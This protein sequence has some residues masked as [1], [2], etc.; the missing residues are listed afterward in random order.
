MA[1]RLAS[2]P[3]WSARPAVF[4]YDLTELAGLDC[5]SAASG[6]IAEAQALAAGLFGARQS[7]FLVNG[8]TAGVQAAILATCGE[9]DTLVIARNSHLSAVTGMA[10][11]GCRPRWVCPAVDEARGV[12]HGVA[13]E[14]IA[15][16]LDAASAAGERVGA[17]LVTSPTYFG[18]CSDVAALAEACHA[19]GVPLL[20]D[21]A[22]GSHLSFLPDASSPLSAV[23]LGADAV[24]QST[25]KTLGSL[26]QSAMLHLGGGAGPPRV[27]AARVESALQALQSSSP[28]YL[29]MASLDAARL[30]L[31]ER[32]LDAFE[33]ALGEARGARAGLERLGC[34]VMGK[35]SVGPWDA[36]FCSGWDPLRLS[37]TPPAGAVAGRELARRLEEDYGVVPEMA[38]HATVVLAL[39]IG[40]Q[41]GDGERIVAAFRDILRAEG[42]G[43]GPAAGDPGGVALHE[44]LALV[45]GVLSSDANSRVV[46]TPR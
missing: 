29:L 25:H 26:T 31:E 2:P 24:A 46:V 39:G 10:L 43:A 37:V 41:A 1:R 40:S 42:A 12:A 3:P 27:D 35:G 9:G 15:A 17:V 14:S 7:F 21:E 19:R 16:A 44:S 38:T 30:T 45:A 11:A 13:P 34:H 20:V 28:S 22:H 32:G 18:C 33:A 36:S 23:D 4:R 6:P 8:C 5:L